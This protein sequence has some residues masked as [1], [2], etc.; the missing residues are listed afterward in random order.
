MERI[1]EMVEEK[2]I[3]KQKKENRIRENGKRRGEM[4]DKD[5]RGMGKKNN[6][7]WEMLLIMR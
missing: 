1:R 6:R 3:K 2:E 4:G 7:M 5:K